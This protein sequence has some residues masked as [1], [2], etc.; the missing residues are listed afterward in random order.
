MHA[1]AQQSTK[2][3]DKLNRVENTKLPLRPTNGKPLSPHKSQQMTKIEPSS[4]LKAPK[5]W[6]IEDFEIGKPLGQGKFGNVYLVRER[7][8]GYI[9]ALKVLFK[10]ELQKC[11]VEHQLRREIEI[12]TNLRHPNILRMYGYFF[13]EDKVY[14]ILEYSAQGE[15]YKHL[16]KTGRF[17]EKTAASYL[18]DIASALEYLHKKHIIHRDIKL[19]NILLSLNGKVKI[20]D[21]GWSV[22]APS[23]RRKT[24][25]GTLDYLPPEMIDGK[26]HDHSVDIWAFGILSYE[27]LTGS[28]PF[29]S[30]GSTAQT[31]QRIKALDLTFPSYVPK[32]ASD[33]IRKLLK[34]EPAERMP[35]S[36]VPEH[37]WIRRNTESVAGQP[38]SVPTKTFRLDSDSET[39]SE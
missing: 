39:S 30:E 34:K 19:E 17:D 14:L 35:L 15:L 27:F 37:P 25:C 5:Q 31:Y 36:K 18:K 23:E 11:E 24:L 12:Q 22:H 9:V 7:K 8:S 4:P 32:D 6:S 29:E 26:G 13:D 16:S 10:K 21:F 33:F 2:R 20:A 3:Q 28:P 1:Y 38:S